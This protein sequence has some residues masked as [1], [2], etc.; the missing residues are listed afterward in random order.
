MSMKIHF[1]SSHLDFFLEK[2]GSVS[3]EQGERFHQ[4]IA[5]ME[6]RYKE[7]G[8]HQCWLIIAGP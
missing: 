6:G 5:A 8:A 2:C 1:L 4:D 3:D 7:N